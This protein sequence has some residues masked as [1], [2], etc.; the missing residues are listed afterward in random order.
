MRVSTNVDFN[1]NLFQFQMLRTCSEP[2]MSKLFHT[3]LS[4][5]GS[6]GCVSPGEIVDEADDNDDLDDLEE[7]MK[8]QVSYA[9]A[10]LT[11]STA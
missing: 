7:A 8:H 2:D 9:Q 10:F 3:Q 11:I 5:D 4:G 1:V 6:E